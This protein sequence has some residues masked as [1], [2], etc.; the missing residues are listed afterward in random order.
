[1]AQLI[2]ASAGESRVIGVRWIDRYLT[3]NPQIRTKPSD[4][5]ERVRARG[6]TREAYTEYFD[7]LERVIREKK[8][9][10]RNISNMDE[11]GM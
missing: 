7:L 11:H 2:L 6:S 1:M 9:L 8:I 3:R 10:P 4:L 5:L